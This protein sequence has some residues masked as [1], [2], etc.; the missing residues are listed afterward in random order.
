MQQVHVIHLHPGVLSEH[1]ASISG[2]LQQQFKQIIE[3]GGHRI[4]SVTACPSEDRKGTDYVVIT[5]RETER[6]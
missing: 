1:A 2:L 5:E 3:K 4:V 6:G